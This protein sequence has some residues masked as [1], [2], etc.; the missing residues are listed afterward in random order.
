ML[1]CQVRRW[2]FKSALAILL[3]LAVGFLVGCGEMPNPEGLDFDREL[4]LKADGLVYR[5]GDDC[6]Y[7]GKAYCTVFNERSRI[8]GLPLHWQGEFK[9][10]KSHGI[11]LLPESRKADDCYEWGEDRGVVRVE[12]RD[13]VEVRNR[14]L[15]GD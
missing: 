8:L 1:R 13:G 5:M 4:T 2:S 6:P 7:T 15:T 10:G 3:A 11:W 14:E 9:D 12:F